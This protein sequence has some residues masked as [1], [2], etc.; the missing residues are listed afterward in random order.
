MKISSHVA[1]GILLDVVVATLA[2]PL[3]GSEITI[4]KI[5]AKAKEETA[6]S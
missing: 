4:K 3:V 1:Y 5:A 2:N 6:I